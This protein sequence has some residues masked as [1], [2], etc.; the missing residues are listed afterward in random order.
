MGKWGFEIDCPGCLTFENV[1]FCL[2]LLEHSWWVV[3]YFFFT[4]EAEMSVLNYHPLRYL[5]ELLN[6]SENAYWSFLFVCLFLLFL[7][8]CGNFWGKLSTSVVFLEV[9]PF[10]LKV[11]IIQMALKAS[12]RCAVFKRCFVYIFNIFIWKDR[13]H[14]ETIK[15]SGENSSS[16]Q[17]TECGIL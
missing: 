12:V 11:K 4:H 15:P 6:R 17:K 7:M 10:H 14:N 13:L 9:V 3:G 8:V 5:D 2:D 1:C 16:R